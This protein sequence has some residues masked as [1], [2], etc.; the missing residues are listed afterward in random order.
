MRSLRFGF[1]SAHTPMHR[2][3]RLEEFIWLTPFFV[4]MFLTPI[5]VVCAMN[6]RREIHD[7]DTETDTQRERDRRTERRTKR[8]RE[9]ETGDYGGD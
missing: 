5:L 7:T 3:P 9:R 6:E 4:F 2:H 8:S 1:H